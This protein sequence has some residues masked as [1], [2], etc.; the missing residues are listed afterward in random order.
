MT[1]IYKKELSSYFINPL[2]YVFVSV[3]LVASALIFCLTTLKAK[4]YDTSSYFTFMIAAFIILIPLLTMKLF[5]EERKMRTE[6]LILTSP[7]TITG[8]VFGKFLA[9][10][11]IFIGSLAVSLVN[12]I[13]LYAIAI[14]E[15]AGQDI[16]ITHIGPVTGQIVGS[17]IG[18]ILIGAAFIAI[19]MFISAFFEDQLAAA[20]TTIGVI[21]FMVAVGLINNA[22]DSDGNRII[23]VYAVRFV[24]DWISVLSRY[25]SFGYGIFDFASV[26][27]Y[28]SIAG[29]FIFLTVRVYTRRRWA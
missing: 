10:F 7:V 18:L 16:E 2:G 21:L 6:Q 15:R 19:G 4:S 13:P 22:A 28:F 29:V 26:L 1:A 3:Y 27:Y 8:M 20:I 9:A 24:L 14:K 25:A 5:S 23:S 11:T 12:L 17:Y